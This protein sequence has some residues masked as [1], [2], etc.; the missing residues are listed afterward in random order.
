MKRQAGKLRR[1]RLIQEGLDQI[2]KTFMDVADALGVS[3][4]L[5]SRTAHGKNNNRRVLRHFLG[6][7]ISPDVLDLPEDLRAE[8]NKTM[9]VV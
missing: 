3:Y 2:G 1:V 4:A 8:T 9:A 7:G 5:V 6:L